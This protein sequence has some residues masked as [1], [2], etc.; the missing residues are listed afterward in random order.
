MKRNGIVRIYLCK[1]CGFKKKAD[2][3]NLCPRCTHYMSEQ[4]F[5]ID[6]SWLDD[7]DNYNN[8]DEDN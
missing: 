8:E 5:G 6:T 3:D 1:Y 7:D 2:G 4:E